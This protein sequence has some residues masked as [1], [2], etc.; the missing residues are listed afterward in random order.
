MVR[1]TRPPEAA[2][3]LRTAGAALVAQSRRTR[4]PIAESALADLRNRAGCAD[5][6]DG[7]T[8]RGG[9]LRG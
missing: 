6:G 1:A 2:Q 3:V 5:D 8:G 7:S 4:K 9:I